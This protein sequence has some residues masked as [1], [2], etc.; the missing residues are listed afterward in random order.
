[1]KL[2]ELKSHLGNLSALKFVQPNGSL[3]P[4][5]FH[6]TEA[7]L[8]SKHFIDCGGTIRTDKVVN[9]QVWTA[10]DTMHRLDPGKLLKIISLY[11]KHFGTEDLEIE[12]EYQTDTTGRYG[13]EFKDE[14]FLLMAKYT[15]CLASDQCGNP[16]DTIKLP[17]AESTSK[18]NSCCT[19]GGGCC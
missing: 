10:S 13:L 12:V 2:S 7:G 6:I 1:M 14:N 11:E 17:L 15:D 9:F 3:V 4:E 18:D 5:H 16:K 8:T 19:P